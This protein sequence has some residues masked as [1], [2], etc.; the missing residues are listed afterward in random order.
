MECLVSTSDRILDFNGGAPKPVQMW[1]VGV[2]SI[3]ATQT[4]RCE[5]PKANTGVCEVK[6]W[7]D[8]LYGVGKASESVLS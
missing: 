2:N 5:S 6:V 4:S 1:G 7:H 3:A 8:E